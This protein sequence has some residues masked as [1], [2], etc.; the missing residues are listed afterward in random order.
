MVTKFNNARINNCI[1]HLIILTNNK[2]IQ[3]NGI[4]V[5]SNTRDL[6]VQYYIMIKL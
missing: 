5:D 2:A 1:N 6:V 3:W 4:Y